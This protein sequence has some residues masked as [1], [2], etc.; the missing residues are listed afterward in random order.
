MR[1]INI[2]NDARRDAE[3]AFGNK[4]HKETIVYKTTTGSTGRNER[5]LK[6][7]MPTTEAALLEAYGDA[8][9]EAK[10]A[11]VDVLMLRCH[12]EPDELTIVST[13]II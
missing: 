1:K 6:A 5:R 10:A 12:V 7:T 13:E 4:G 9:A 11:G 2:A 8:L 3:V